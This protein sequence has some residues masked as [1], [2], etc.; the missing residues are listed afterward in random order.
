MGFVNMED[1]ISLFH[2]VSNCVYVAIVWII[3]RVQFFGVFLLGLPCCGYQF[4]CEY[5]GLN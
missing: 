1:Y 2:K 3:N 4:I 5:K